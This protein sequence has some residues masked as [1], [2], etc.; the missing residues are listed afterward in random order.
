MDACSPYDA[1]PTHPTGPT[2]ERTTGRR[3]PK[4]GVQ[5]SFPFGIPENLRY[6]RD[7]GAVSQGAARPNDGGRDRLIEMSGAKGERSS[8]N[9]E[10]TSRHA[11]ALGEST[12]ASRL[13][14]VMTPTY[15][16]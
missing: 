14:V 9:G 3:I 10:R 15:H 13:F 1:F 7:A 11:G 8:R 5:P 2:R 12:P 16:P 6:R 4:I